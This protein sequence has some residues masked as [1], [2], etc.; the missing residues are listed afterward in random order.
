M[1]NIDYMRSL[2]HKSQL[3]FAALGDPV[4]QELLMSLMDSQH[5]SVKELTSKTKLS[6]PAI[7]HHLKVLKEANIIVERKKG[8]EIF[9]RPQTGQNYQAVKELMDIIDEQIKRQEI[10]A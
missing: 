9:Y 8:R 1:K 5:L 6:R 4:R 10:D 2:L 3:F 7:S